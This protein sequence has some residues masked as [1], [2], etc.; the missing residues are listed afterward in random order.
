MMCLMRSRKLPRWIGMCSAWQSVSPAA[1]NSAVEQ[2]R[3]SLM[4][5]E[6]EARP[7]L[8]V[9]GM[10]VADERLAGFVDDRGEGSADDFDGDGVETTLPPHEVGRWPKAGGVMLIHRRLHDTPPHPAG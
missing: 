9:G 6:C 5:V 10:R 1:L 2:S 3:R 7:L 4:L 8:A